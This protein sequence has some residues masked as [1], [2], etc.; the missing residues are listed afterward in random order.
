MFAPYFMAN[1]ECACCAPVSPIVEECG[2]ITSSGC[3][4]ATKSKVRSQ[5]IIDLPAISHT[6]S[7]RFNHAGGEFLVEW[8][9][10]TPAGGFPQ[11]GFG[12]FPCCNLFGAVIGTECGNEVIPFISFGYVPATVG[13][14][15]AVGYMINGT[16]ASAIL[17]AFN[18]PVSDPSSLPYD[19]TD[20]DYS[21]AYAGSSTSS[22]T[23]CSGV[24]GKTR[25]ISAHT[26]HILS[27]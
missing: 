8:A 6:G 14:D 26:I 2:C 15:I 17:Y 19:C 20:M 24:G 7:G 27:V 4:D 23:D 12:L 21:W 10:T 22:A 18:D 1:E 25:I 16:G 3:T 9:A 5:M 11:S 13:S